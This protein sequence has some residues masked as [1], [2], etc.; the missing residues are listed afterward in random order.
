MSVL[1]II[2]GVVG[3]VVLLLG[4]LIGLNFLAVARMRKAE[5]K[6]APELEGRVGKLMKRKAGAL[7]YFYSP[8]CAPCR[9]MTPIV[10]EMASRDERVQPVDISR[11][12]TIARRFGVMATPTVVQVREGL[13][14]RVLVGPQPEQVL[15]GLLV[16]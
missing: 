9:A 8:S 2:G 1:A 15:R 6:A 10:K 4:A 13:V 12:L 3:L 5:G 16:G 14:T 7:F 11:D